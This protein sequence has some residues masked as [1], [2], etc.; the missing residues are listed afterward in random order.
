MTINQRIQNIAKK[1]YRPYEWIFWSATPPEYI[2]KTL[3]GNWYIDLTNAIANSLQ[4]VKAFW[5]TLI[6]NVPVWYKE[7]E[8]ITNA[9]VVN[10]WT[11]QIDTWIVADVDDMEFDI[12]ATINN[13]SSLSR[14][15]LQSRLNSS[16]PIYWLS[17]SASWNTFIGS[18]S[19]TNVAVPDLYRQDG[20][21]YHVN[22]QCKNGTIT[23]T[24]EDLTDEITKTN[25][26][27]YSFNAWTTNIW[28]FGNIGGWWT[29]LAWN[30]S[31]H[32]A[33]IKKSWKKVFEY[34]PCKNGNDVAGFY[35]M[36]TWN[37]VTS[38][39]ENW[40]TAWNDNDPTPTNLKT[41]TWNN[42]QIKYQNYWL[43]AWYSKLDYIEMNNSVYYTITGFKLNWHDTVRFSYE[44][45]NANSACNILWS[46]TTPNAQDNRSIYIWN[47]VSAKYL[48]Y[49]W[50]TYSSYSLANKKYDVVIT[51]T[52]SLW[53]ETEETREEKDFTCSVDFNVWI[54]WTSATSAKFIWKLYWNIVV[55]WRL[56]LVPCKRDIDDV[57][58]YYDTFSS[59]F[60]EPARTSG[61]WPVA[62]N[63]ELPYLYFD[64]TTETIK[65][66]L[67]NEATATNLLSV[68]NTKDV[69]EILTWHV[70]KNIW[71]LILNWTENRQVATNEWLRQFYSTNTQWII[72]NSVSLIS[73]IA[74]YGC[75]A[76]TRL[77]YQYWCYSWWTWNLCFQMIWSQSLITV[78]DRTDRLKN[79]YKSWTPVVVV[80]PLATPTTETVTWQ[81]LNIQNGTNKIEITQWSILPLP[82]EIQ[83]HATS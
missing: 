69:Q 73:N 29:V 59:T 8:T 7:V 60:F 75:T 17:W 67:N 20:H 36:I 1:L 54:T 34:V 70:T 31:I 63:I 25:T 78:E 26:G 46:Y 49:D 21:K 71:I 62:W 19:W 4:Y 27:S 47:S 56:N 45:T 48:R 37:F 76:S 3:T 18:F 79:Q 58:W 23:L 32:S 83:F 2:T 10:V 80:Y 39:I 13:A 42:G 66:S 9:Q 35:D 44:W 77:D 15:V 61:D 43:P 6:W 5:W 30:T 38:S 65:D 41:I 40:L 14:Y 55:D 22:S 24:V 52:W 53:M 74:P 11:G 81:T 57:I 16:A 68:W 51:P 64:W 33:Y 82:L 50:W 72:A 28:L 12:V